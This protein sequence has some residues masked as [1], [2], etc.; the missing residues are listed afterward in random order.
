MFIAQGGL[1]CGAFAI[2]LL[3]AVTATTAGWEIMAVLLIAIVP[4]CCC[5]AGLYD[6]LCRHRRHRVRLLA[7]IF[8]SEN[9]P[10]PLHL[11]PSDNKF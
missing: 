1:L 10:T 6:R 7:Q 8:L 4:A 11:C 3:A 2:A 5:L 9:E